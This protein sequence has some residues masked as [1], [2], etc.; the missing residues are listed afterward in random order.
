MSAWTTLFGLV[1]IGD[2]LAW[3]AACAENAGA[4]V[5]PVVG[6]GAGIAGAAAAAGG[7]PSLVPP[8][9]VRGDAPPSETPGEMHTVPA[10]ASGPAGL[11]VTHS[12]GF[13][14]VTT[15]DGT[16]VSATSTAP[17]SYAAALPD[18]SILAGNADGTSTITAPDGS[19]VNYNAAG[20][21]TSSAGANLEAGGSVN[22]PALHHDV[23][24]ATSDGGY[25]VSHP[26]G[27]VD[28]HHPDGTAIHVEADGRTWHPLP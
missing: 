8:S 25:N 6:I 23:T 26:D 15:P 7:I 21:P 22:A 18:G 24:N 17:N 12:D 5:A 9:P 28:I 10:A 2:L 16:T 13:T 19:T 14:T 4:G 27:S 3:C 1:A 20:Q 11:T